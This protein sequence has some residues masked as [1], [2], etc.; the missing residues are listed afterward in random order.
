MANKD[1]VECN[2]VANLVKDKL[3]SSD[4]SLAVFGS[5]N[6][7]GDSN[8]QKPDED[9]DV[10]LRVVYRGEFPRGELAE[11]LNPGECDNIDLLTGGYVDIL[12]LRGNYHGRK[13]LLYCSTTAVYEK[14]CTG[15][16]NP[17]LLFKTPKAPGR[18]ISPVYHLERY[19]LRGTINEPIRLIPLR[20]GRIAIYNNNNFVDGDFYLTTPQNQILT[21]SE[22]L[23]SEGYLRRGRLSI[24][25]M[26]RRL[27]PGEDL[28][29]VSD[30]QDANWSADFR[31]K[32]DG[33][34]NG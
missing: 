11:L 16:A 22:L 8:K 26:M 3:E 14:A 31:V 15:G 34:L 27:L 7:G 20:N 28:T 1:F 9:S 21:Q 24:V 6:N 32:M 30:Y 5:T 29:K 17:L 12:G 2:L 23:D 10:D 13:I 4:S 19:G 18:R 33:R 25:T